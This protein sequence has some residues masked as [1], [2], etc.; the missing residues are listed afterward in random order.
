MKFKKMLSAFC[1]AAGLAVAVPTLSAH[2]GVTAPMTTV[3]AAEGW[4]EDA[5]GIF[6]EQNGTRLTGLQ[7]IGSAHYYF[8]SYGYR[9]T[10]PVKIDN[11]IYYFTPNAIG[12]TPAGALLTGQTG[13]LTNTS[14][15]N[16]YYYLT[17]KANGQVT[18]N[19][20]IKIKGKYFYA[21][22]NG[23][24]NLGTIKV[25][26]KLYHI[27]KSGRLTG[28]MKKSSF[29][30]KYYYASANGVLKTGLQ[31][32]GKRLYFFNK[33]TGQRQSGTITAGKYTY[34][35]NTQSGYART[36][37]IKLGSAESLKYYYY[38]SNFRQYTGLQTIKGKKYYFNPKHGNAREEST[39]CKIGKHWYYFN[40]NGVLQTGFQT[41]NGKRYYLSGSGV[42]KKGWQTVD[43]L[44]YYMDQK[45]AVV[46]TGWFEY[47]GNKYYLN[48]VKTS[49]TYGA[50]KTGWVRISGYW[51]YFNN[52]GTQKTGWLTLTDNSGN[53][54]KYY[55]DPNNNG[56]MVT[57]TKK[58]NGTTY[59]FGNSG[60][61]TVSLGGAWS[62]HVN[63]R[64]CVVTIYK[65]S[66][67]VKAMICS[68]AKNGTATPTGTFTLKDKLR[69]HELIGPSWGQYCSHITN[70]ILFHSVTY[71]RYH[72]NRSLFASAYN[73][74]GNPASAGCI[75]LQVIDAK[76]MYDNL[77]V[78]TTVIISDNE[79]TPLGKPT[80]SKI[81]STQNYDPTD[82]NI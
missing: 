13:L 62:I 64:K 48:P 11:A 52:D 81:P 22:A 17:N 2:I 9:V 25:G 20:W 12:T 78:G 82:P 79:P 74:L 6:Y 68:T 63:R 53:V 50:A 21:D 38:G 19:K 71:S 73:N 31:K 70:D 51:Y 72:D 61:I 66:T 40:E 7:Q 24:I 54:K 69:W 32:I 28:G 37:W 15:K 3:F 46:K 23:K 57:G 4:G 18:A 55:L 29:D 41:I 45:T 49:S 34:Y 59:N 56:K 14:E 60:A 16:V 30:K 27:T 80:I 43:N 75:R 33:T 36:G 76:W 58:I 77:P 65:G 47:K 39:W 26:K 42:R 10:G 5:N 35:F 67:P 1:L 44:K 8:S